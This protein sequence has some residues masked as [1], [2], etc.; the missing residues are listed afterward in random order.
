MSNTEIFYYGRWIGSV[1]SLNSLSK[2]LEGVYRAFIAPQYLNNQWK[3][4]EVRIKDFDNFHSAKEY[5]KQMYI[6][7]YIAL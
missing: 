7:A 4:Y 1:K 5:V 2:N 3:P 6:A